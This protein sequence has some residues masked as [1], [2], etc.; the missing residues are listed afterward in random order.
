MPNPGP[1]RL[2]YRTFVFDYEHARLA[3]VP[4]NLISEVSS[5]V[6]PDTAQ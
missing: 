3:G 2:A 4:A 6:D 5:I 1:H